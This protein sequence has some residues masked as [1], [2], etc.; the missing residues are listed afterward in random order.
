MNYRTAAATLVLAAAAGAQAIAQQVH[1]DSDP[2]AAFGSYRTFAWK[3]ERITSPDPALN[4]PI[5]QSKIH[6]EVEKQLAARGLTLATGNPDV[7]VSFRLG[8]G[9]ERDV[10]DYPI[11]WRWGGWRREVVFNDKGTLVIDI[12]DAA[13]QQMIWRA[14]CIDTASNANRLDDHLPKDVKKAFDQ[15][16]VKKIK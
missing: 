12:A 2:A 13:R 8:T 9:M 16:P 15:F 11:G 10:I 5:V 3:S 14:V 6:A 7:W 4:N 1:T